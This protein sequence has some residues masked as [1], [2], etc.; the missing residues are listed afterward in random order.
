MRN[1]KQQKSALEE[2]H[3]LYLIMSGLSSQTCQIILLGDASEAKLRLW[4]SFT[5]IGSLMPII[6]TV[7]IFSR[8]YDPNINLLVLYLGH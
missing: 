8:Q 7:N 6:N 4:S 5:G 2:G 1:N 3:L